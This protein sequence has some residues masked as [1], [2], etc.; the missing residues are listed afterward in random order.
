MAVYYRAKYRESRLS[1]T[2]RVALF[3]PHLAYFFL[4]ICLPALWDRNL[5]IS[6]ALGRPN[7]VSHINSVRMY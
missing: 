1:S 5:A 7:L 4:N 2:Q 6:A 3:R